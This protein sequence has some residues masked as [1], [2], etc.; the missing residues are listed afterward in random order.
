MELQQLRYVLA[1]AEERNFTRAA[2]KCFVMQSAL[3]HQIKSLEKE[4]GVELFART[5]R[6]V[7]LTD[8]GAAFL[9]AARAA[10]DAADRAVADAAAATGEIRGT[11]TIGVIPT[12]TAID[13][14]AALGEFHRAHPTVQIRLRGGGS[15]EFIKAIRE[16]SIDVAVLGL[17]DATLPRGVATQVLA[18]ERLVAVLGPGH[19]L[20]ERRRLRLSD[21]ADET[22]VDFPAGTPGRAPSDLAFASAG[23]PRRV[24]FEAMGTDLMLDLVR[25]DL[26]ITLL[27]PAVVPANSGLV[28]IP[29]T[30]GPTRI[31]YLTWSDFNPSPAALAFLRVAAVA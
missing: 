11:L 25:H 22:F 29:V 26:A 27:A 9:P 10:L 19:R 15:D 4:L 23:V 13:I 24:A 16:G 1:V 18:R 28:T 12:V 7:E 3:S 14:P 20:A 31:E 8:A 17:P 6:R 2:E 21:L 5:S 30:D